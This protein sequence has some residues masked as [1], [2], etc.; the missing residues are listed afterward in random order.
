M[1]CTLKPQTAMPCQAAQRLFGKT[2]RS[3]PGT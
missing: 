1:I 2:V 3:I